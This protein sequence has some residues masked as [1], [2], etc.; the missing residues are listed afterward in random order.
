VRARCYTPGQG[1]GDVITNT[2]IMNENGDMNPAGLPVISLATDKENYFDYHKGIYVA[3]A[4]FNGSSFSGNYELR[5]RASE[6]PVHLEY[7]EN[8]G[9]RIFNMNIGTRIRGELVRFSRTESIVSVCAFRIR[10][11]ESF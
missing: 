8:N 10:C 7:F 4:T 3:G 5:G 1:L 6:R 9:S 2:Y 11:N